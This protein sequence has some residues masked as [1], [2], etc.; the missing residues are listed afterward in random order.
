[1]KKINPIKSIRNRFAELQKIN[2]CIQQSDAICPV[3]Y[4]QITYPNPQQSLQISI[5]LYVNYMQLYSLGLW[6]R[7][8]LFLLITNQNCQNILN[9]SFI[10]NV[11]LKKIKIQV[12]NPHTFLLNHKMRSKYY[13]GEEVYYY[14]N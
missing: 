13:I 1:M 10:I 8:F 5:S 7:A 11:Y 9:R 3:Q 12:T 4:L 2:Y 14:G 6:D